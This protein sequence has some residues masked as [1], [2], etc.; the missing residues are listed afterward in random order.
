MQAILLKSGVQRNILPCIQPAT[1]H[2]QTLSADHIRY[3]PATVAIARL[4]HDSAFGWFPE[5][6]IAR[7]D[8]VNPPEVPHTCRVFNHAGCEGFLLAA[9]VCRTGLS[10]ERTGVQA[11]TP[12]VTAVWAYQFR[13]IPWDFPEGLSRL[14]CLRAYIVR[15][16]SFVQLFLTGVSVLL[17][18]SPSGV[19]DKQ[20]PG[21]PDQQ[22]EITCFE[23]QEASKSEYV[24]LIS[25][26]VVIV[27]T[28]ASRRSLHCILALA[29]ANVLPAESVLHTTNWVFCFHD[30][31]KCC[32]THGC[33]SF[34]AIHSISHSCQTFIGRFFET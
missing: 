34:S 20:V 18:L 29:S 19:P 4:V 32:Y 33:N 9:M 6:L 30:C 13:L 1:L 28:N 12:S 27:Q 5:P 11:L 25:S 7:I 17:T 10:G 23:I 16:Q 26:C 22:R 24:Y 15:Q 21:Q 2:G 3:T 31:I 14:Y 8:A